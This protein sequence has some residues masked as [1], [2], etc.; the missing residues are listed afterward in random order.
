MATQPDIFATL[1]I[2]ERIIKTIAPLNRLR[3]FGWQTWYLPM[4]ETTC[5]LLRDCESLRTLVIGADGH[6]PTIGEF[7]GFTMILIGSA[8]FM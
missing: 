6:H 3:M 2:I 4:S 7:R 1:D 5:T 8:D